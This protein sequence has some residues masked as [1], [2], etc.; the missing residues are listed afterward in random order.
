MNKPNILWITT[1]SQRYDT[2]GCMGNRFVTTPNLDRLAKNGRI[3]NHCYCQNPLCMPS[4]ASFMT[5]RYPRTNGARQ[6]GQTLP[7]HEVLVSRRMA[8]SGYL[9]GMVGRLH[10]SAG[11]F[12]ERRRHD[13]G[14][15]YWHYSPIPFRDWREKYDHA[16]TNEYAYWLREKGIIDHEQYVW[17]PNKSSPRAVRG[18]RYVQAGIEPELHDTTWSADMAVQFIEANTTVDSPWMLNLN[19]NAPHHPFDPPLKFL[20]PYLDRLDEIP[21]PNYTIGELDNKG[22]FQQLTH[23]G[24]YNQPGVFQ[25][26][27]MNDEDHRLISAAYWADIDLVD[28]QIGRVLDT[29]DRIGQCEN[30]MVIFHSDHGEMLGDH[31]MYLKGP[32]FYDPMV[33]VPLII[34]WP[35]TIT[36]TENPSQAMVE[37][38][39]IAPTVLE[40]AGLPV[41]PGM[42]GQSIYPILSGEKSED[43]HRDDVYCEHYKSSAMYKDP[44]PYLTMVR[45]DRHKLVVLH[46][47]DEGELYD[48]ESDP[49]ETV[50]HWHDP[51]YRDVQ[52]AMMKRLCD[53]MAWTVDP[54]P[55]R[56]NNF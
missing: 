50:N 2:L 12:A 45:S 21:L 52:L 40:A 26:E 18:S 49:A 32:F 48:L 20:E 34:A 37:L 9:C 27:N 11:R 35:G 14:Y 7:E 10:A 29:L 33:R 53:R 19:L 5:G 16:A 41:E 44:A 47:A 30:T 4:R 31:G 3:F 28:A 51:E 25:Y 15:A 17:D 38:V 46:S 23:N 24:A 56:E 22:S 43:R 13:D 55:E 54:L 8:E 39:D 42:Q 6:N 36:P 1:D